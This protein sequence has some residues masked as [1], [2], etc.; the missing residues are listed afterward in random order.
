MGAVPVY[1]DIDEKT[2]LIDPIDIENKITKKTKAI[3]VVHLYGLMCDMSKIMKISKKYKIPVI[4]DCAQ[5]F[6]ELTTKE[7]LEQLVL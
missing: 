1:C 2:F 4:E 5:C 7:Y 3:M 6:W